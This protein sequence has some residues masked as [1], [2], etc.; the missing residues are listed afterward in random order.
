MLRHLFYFYKPL[1]TTNA[2]TSLR[3]LPSPLSALQS[4]CGN[5]TSA[6]GVHITPDDVVGSFVVLCEP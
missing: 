4:S 3:I 6:F 5:N 2:V 1:N